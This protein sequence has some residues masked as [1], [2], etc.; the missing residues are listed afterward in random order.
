MN[1]NCMRMVRVPLLVKSGLRKRDGWPFAVGPDE[2]TTFA[3]FCPVIPAPGIPVNWGWLKKLKA[4][5]RYSSVFDSEILKV[6]RM[7]TSKLFTPSV[8]SVLRPTVAPLGKPRPSIQRTS[9]G[10][11]QVSVSASGLRNPDAQLL[12]PV[13]GAT[14]A[15]VLIGAF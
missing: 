12:A 7:F 6:L 14:T 13:V 10:L 2:P 4:S 15:R 1:F 8:N 3:P 9:P 11:T 5:N